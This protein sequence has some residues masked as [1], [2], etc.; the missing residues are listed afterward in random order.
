MFII[1]YYKIA[2][3]CRSAWAVL[4]LSELDFCF[5]SEVTLCMTKDCS[6]K[7]HNQLAVNMSISIMLLFILLIHLFILL[8]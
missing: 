4:T 1:F 7:A 6:T 8:I 5:Q 3:Q 2:T